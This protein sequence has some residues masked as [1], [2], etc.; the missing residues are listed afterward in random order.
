MFLDKSVPLDSAW[1]TWSER[2][3]EFTFLPLGV[4]IAPVLYSAKAGHATAIRAPDEIQF[5]A[6]GLRGETVA[7]ET[8]FADTRVAFCTHKPDPF[9]LRG[10]FE[11][12]EAG[13]WGLRYWV[14]FGISAEDGST[15][16]YDPRTGVAVV[17]VD[18]RFVAF[19]A[20]DIPA[21]ATGHESFAALVEDFDQNGYFDKSTRADAA[22]LMALRFNLEMTPRLAFAAA[23]ADTRD[24]AVAKACAALAGDIPNAPTLHAGRHAGALDAVRDVIGWN[25]V[26]DRLNRRPTTTASRIWGLGDAV[27]Y[28][29]QCFAALMAGLL[30]P[31]LARRNFDVAMGSATPQGNIACL[32]NPK[33]AWVDR[34]QAPHGAFVAW[35]IFQR[36][37]DRAFLSDVFDALARNQLWWRANR[38]PDGR[39]LV[40]CGTSDVGDAMYRGTAFGARNE[41]GMD[42][43]P[44]HDEARYDPATRTLSTLDVG[45]NSALAL[46]AEMLALIAAEIG[47]RDE[48]EQFA[49]LADETR[50][51]IRRELWDEARGLFA[52]RQRDGGF[53]RSVSPTSFFPLL[54]G[55]ADDAQVRRLLTHLDDPAMFGGRYPLP[56]VSRDDPAYAEQIYWRGRIW[57]NVNWLVWQGLRRYRLDA[58]ASSLVA[59]SFAMFEESW[60]SHRWCGENYDGDTGRIDERPGNDPFYTWGAMLPLMAVGDIMD[61]GPWGGWELVNDGQ[62]VRLGPIMSPAGPVSVAVEDGQMRLLGADGRAIFETSYRGRLRRIRVDPF[63]VSVTFAEGG[64]AFAFRLGPEASR[65]LV[66]VRLHGVATTTRLEDGH[67]VADLGGVEAGARLDWHLAPADPA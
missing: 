62:P 67:H 37:G 59:R 3:G 19:A 56:N 44:T 63:L 45:L 28:N 51:L 58:Q 41:T 50:E 38:D 40:S 9:V 26:Y 8:H 54:C 65:R 53:V 22:P 4:R 23:V 27:W 5:G 57:P 29:D 43:S 49:S 55:A 2:P 64:D 47:R 10:R 20:D 6:H 7:Y 12:L 24:L 66:A 17:E 32:V 21:L 31:A 39:G 35:M 61:I 30:D 48:A 52:N 33:D 16:H 25:T 15:V 60:A 14:T 13:E 36:T 34:T 1:N 42:N 18:F 11:T 46:D